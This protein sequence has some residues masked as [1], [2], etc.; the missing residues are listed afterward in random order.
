MKF[1]ELFREF[2]S[3]GKG[4]LDA[5]ALQRLVKEVLGGAVSEAEV[6]TTLKTSHDHSM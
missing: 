4:E 3:Q 5:R 6:N 1:K 2:D